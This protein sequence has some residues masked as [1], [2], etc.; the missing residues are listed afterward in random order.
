MPAD[1]RIREA[2]KHNPLPNAGYV[3]RRIEEPHDLDHP[4]ALQIEHIFPQFAGNTW[5]GDGVREWGDFSEEER[6]AYR[7]ALPTIGNLALLE[8]ELNA[9]ASNKPFLEK[10]KYYEKS[11]VPSTKQL[12]GTPVW[13]LDGIADRTQALTRRFLEIWR[14]PSVAGTDDPDYLV[15]ILDVQRKPGYYPGWQ[16]EFEYVSVP[17]RNLGSPKHE[18]PI[19]TH[20]RAPL[21]DQST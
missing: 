3:L 15:P 18:E 16:S 12:T 1:D 7:E 17:R 5:S 21:G 13:D 8:P 11:K 4:D 6:A 2:L 9:A 14:R 20:L 19:S 10:T